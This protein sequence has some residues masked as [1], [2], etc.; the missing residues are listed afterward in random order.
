MGHGKGTY[1]TI[2]PDRAQPRDDPLARKLV[3]SS[4]GFSARAFEAKLERDA[5]E[6]VLSDSELRRE[7]ILLRREVINLEKEKDAALLQV[8]Q[9]SDI[10]ASLRDRL[11]E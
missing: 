2:S 7:L 1:R 9:L 3:R 11:E 5:A 4:T 6:L 8:R 10:V